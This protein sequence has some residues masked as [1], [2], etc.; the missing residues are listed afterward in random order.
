MNQHVTINSKHVKNHIESNLI[1][2]AKVISIEDHITLPEA[3]SK[4]TQFIHEK[5][6]ERIPDDIR[7][8]VTSIKQS[9]MSSLKNQS[10][11]GT[12]RQMVQLLGKLKL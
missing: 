9:L 3:E 12:E 6:N 7:E 8:M 10:I 2:L 1:Q 11:T 5:Y 4:V